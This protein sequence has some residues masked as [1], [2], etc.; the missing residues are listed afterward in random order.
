MI[1]YYEK[2]SYILLRHSNWVLFLKAIFMLVS[3]FK[4]VKIRIRMPLANIHYLYVFIT[5]YLL[6]YEIFCEFTFIFA[7]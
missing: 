6:Y 7:A 3:I 5:L 4:N 1:C 2:Y